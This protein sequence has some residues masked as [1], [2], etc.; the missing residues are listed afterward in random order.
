ME[1]IQVQVADK[2][3]VHVNCCRLKKAGQLLFNNAYNRE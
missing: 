1:L 3:Q 2:A